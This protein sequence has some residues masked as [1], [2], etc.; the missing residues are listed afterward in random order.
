MW[1]PWH[2]AQGCRRCPGWDPTTPFRCSLGWLPP[3]PRVL[4]RVC[5]LTLRAPLQMT[6]HWGF[7]TQSFI[8]LGAGGQRS[9]QVAQG[10]VPSRGSRGR[11]FLPPQ[12]LGGPRRSWAGGH[13]AAICLC[14]C[15]HLGPTQRTQDD[16]ILRSL[17]TT[18]KTL[19]QTGSHPLVSGLGVGHIGATIQPTAAS[20]D[21]LCQVGAWGPACGWPHR[22]PGL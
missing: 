19:F 14:Q 15:L 11:Y 6:T 1:W 10:H 12:A 8:L 5:V 22:R 3:L 13:V 7:H 2:L 16:H 17:M 20:K 4:P 9:I 18:E 21:Q